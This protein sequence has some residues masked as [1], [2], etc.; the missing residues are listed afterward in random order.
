MEKHREKL[1]ASSVIYMIYAVFIYAL[2]YI[3]VIV[4]VV[5]SFNDSRNNLVW[6][7]FTTKWYEELWTDSE[8]WGILL[9]TLIIAIVASLFAIVIGT[10][11]AV[12]MSKL[13]FKGKGLLD[14][15]V[16]IPIIIPE[17]VLAVA[18]LLVL[19]LVNV[20]FGLL[21]MSLGNASLVLPY[22]YVTVKSRLV[23]MDPS[24]EEASLDLGANRAY[25]FQH[26]I[27]PEIV[28]G[29]VSGAF[30][31]FTL[32]FD[33]LI[34]SNFM[35]NAKT[36]TLP[37]LTYSQ[38]KKGIS[39]EINAMCSI[40]LL[41]F[42]IVIGGYFFV[43]FINTKRKAAKEQELIAKTVEKEMRL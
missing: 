23:G 11:G 20:P 13:K 41:A 3:P 32:S 37:I 28:P 42:F 38:L 31:A 15:A 39:P 5:F 14:S 6:K 2:L 1:K 17:I 21:A 36:N 43:N 27:I 12:G 9:N 33:D 35:A 26:I 10:L 18:T 29:I 4:L 34:I 22:V 7:S 19:Q 30:M 40:I 24:I 25:T 8:L 16:Y